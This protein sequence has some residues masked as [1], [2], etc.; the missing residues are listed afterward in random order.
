MRVFL[1]REKPRRAFL[2]EDYQPPEIRKA[3]ASIP[4]SING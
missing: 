1:C 4:D 2:L 3:P